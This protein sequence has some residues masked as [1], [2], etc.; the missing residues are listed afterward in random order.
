MM[1]EIALQRLVDDFVVTMI[2]ALILKR[3]FP[4]NA[5][6]QIGARNEFRH[7]L[8]ERN[9]VAVW[10]SKKINGGRKNPPTREN[11]NLQ[12]LNLSQALRGRKSRQPLSEHV[13][14]AAL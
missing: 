2:L 3:V 14:V 11:V 5:I 13:D 4:S 7:A 9:G 10:H 12:A 1:L 8:W 6:L